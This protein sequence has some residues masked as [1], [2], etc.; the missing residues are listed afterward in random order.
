MPPLS[1]CL[2]AGLGEW[3]LRRGL[4]T[5]L[6]FD[7]RG[8]VPISHSL[9]LETT[10]DAIPLPRHRMSLPNALSIEGVGTWRIC[11]VDNFPYARWLILLCSSGVGNLYREAQKVRG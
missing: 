5:L 11:Q 2:W 7:N 4:I 1:V 9:S 10:R 6:A 8:Y 3:H